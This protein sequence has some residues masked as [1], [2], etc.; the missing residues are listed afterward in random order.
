M[1]SSP[2]KLSFLN[3]LAVRYKNMALTLNSKT[4]SAKFT[5]KGLHM[6]IAEPVPLQGVAIA[7]V[8]TN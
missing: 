3:L 8:E 4:S 5:L 7:T 1:E 6:F 2:S